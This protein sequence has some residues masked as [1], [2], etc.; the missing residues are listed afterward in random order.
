MILSY[1]ILGV[2]RSAFPPCWQ[3]DRVV[4]NEPWIKSR[5]FP[6]RPN[7][8]AVVM[9]SFIN[10]LKPLWE[11]L[12]VEEKLFCASRFDFC[13]LSAFQQ[14]LSFVCSCTGSLPSKLREKKHLIQ[15]TNSSS[16]SSTQA[17]FES[18][19]VKDLY[20]NLWTVEF[21]LFFLWLISWP[22]NCQDKTLLPKLSLS[23]L[24]IPPTDSH[25][26]G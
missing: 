18:V 25:C 12:S 13:D 5:T 1:L 26:F 11:R 6:T 17:I 2:Y 8:S 14:W 21:F 19:T 16:T 7:L 22:L 24:A 3:N 9:L 4:V 15:F 23:F 20:R 10:L